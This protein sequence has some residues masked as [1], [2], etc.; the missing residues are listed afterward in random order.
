MTA[1]VLSKEELRRYKDR[2]RKQ[3]KRF[4]DA[5][6]RRR[7]ANIV[8]K[9]LD[10][11][12]ADIDKPTIKHDQGMWI[13]T[14]ERVQIGEEVKIT[15]GTAGCVAGHAVALYGDIIVGGEFEFIVDILDGKTVNYTSY[16]IDTCVAAEN[17]KLGKDEKG[18]YAKWAYEQIPSR[19]EKL[20]GL[21]PAEA[22][23]LFQ[24]DNRPDVIR[25]IALDILR[26]PG[27]LDKQMRDFYDKDQ[28]YRVMSYDDRVRSE[29]W[30]FPFDL[31]HRFIRNT[32]VRRDLLGTYGNKLTRISA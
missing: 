13:R 26:N 1:P 20:L 23:L 17:A 15:C 24:P 30:R 31:A 4:Q 21:T 27:N 16:S 28:F 25:A 5:P 11:H 9:V 3:Q 18:L 29:N 7:L 2:V 10:A 12:N 32:S 8:N 6:P 22:G 19:A 14:D